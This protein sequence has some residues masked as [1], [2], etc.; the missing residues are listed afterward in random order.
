MKVGI[1]MIVKNEEALLARC[2]ESVKDFDEIVICDTGS[3]DNTVEIAKKYTDKVHTDYKWGDSFCKARN[4]ALSKMSK[5]MDWV[6][7]IDADEYLINSYEEVK[8][9]VEKSKALA[10]NINVKSE[11]GGQV[12]KFPRLFKNTP[13]VYW[14][15]DIHNLLNIPGGEDAD[16]TTV[17]GYSPAH[18]KDPDRSMRILEKSLKDNPKLIR[19]KYYL[20]REYYYRE[21]WQKAID[22]FDEYTR[23]SNFIGE[24]NDAW[25]LRAECL[26]K[27]SKY[28]EACDS[29]WQAIKYNA[30]FKEALLFI[31]N[32]MDSV[33]KERWLSF[34]NLADSRGVVFNRTV[35]EKGSEYYDELF[36]RD[37]NMSRYEN[38]YK[39]IGGIV[40]TLE[41][42]DIGCGLG[43]LSKYVKNYS[44]FDFS[45][46]AIQSIKNGNPGLNV[47][48]GDAYDEENYA[49]Y[50]FFVCTEVLEH[51]DDKKLLAQ[52]TTGA[53]FLCSVPSFS[54]PSHIRTYT[55]GSVKKLPLD[56]KNIYRFNWRGGK[57][58]ENNEETGNYILLIDSIKR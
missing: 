19:E 52:V 15:N 17:Y 27:L 37:S 56:I 58:V 48:V 31:A 5:D 13:E 6:L 14:V 54:D 24:R 12:H 10:I 35:S 21:Q 57:W 39:K 3:E 30:N 25:L 9:V 32:H 34:A 51:L 46:Y 26:A 50:D 40:G 4:Y 22:M 16:I 53:R 1:S 28:N 2:L 47:W 44:G 20:A 49:G 33:N 23:E 38:I 45:R 29:A 42:L 18:Q 8:E 55:E 36:K 43:E 11:K 41:I 7:T